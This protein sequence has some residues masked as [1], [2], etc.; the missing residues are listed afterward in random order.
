MDFSG[1][2]DLKIIYIEVR[3]FALASRNI[4]KISHQPKII[5]FGA[6]GYGNFLFRSF[7]YFH[8]HSMG[9]A[10]GYTV[11][12]K[13]FSKALLKV[14]TESAGCERTLKASA[15]RRAFFCL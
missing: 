3:S 1:V 12:P 13:W 14:Y 15:L 10:V 11:V 6:K 9:R 5:I 7:R 4:L 2:F 8:P